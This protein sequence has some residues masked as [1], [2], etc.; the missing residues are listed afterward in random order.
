MKSHN[1]NF[2]NTLGSSFFY[3]LILQPTRITGH[4]A[5][6]IDNIFF[7][8]LE[9]FTISGNIVYDLTNHVPNFLVFNDF[10]SLPSNFK[11]CK[12]DYSTFNQHAFMNELQSINWQ[13]LFIDHNPSAMFNSFYQKLVL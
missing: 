12:R 4:S 13:V 8:S 1:D 11:M 10:E 5:T 6:L 3:P 9:Y 7:N 2:L